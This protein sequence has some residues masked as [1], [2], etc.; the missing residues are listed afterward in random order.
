MYNRSFSIYWL[1]W[2]IKKWNNH[3]L[4][5]QNPAE[6]TNKKPS[7]DSVKIVLLEFASDVPSE[8]TEITTLSC[9]M[10]LTRMI[11]TSLSICLRIS[12]QLLK[13]KLSWCSTKCKISSLITTN[14]QKYSKNS[15]ESRGILRMGI[16][17]RWLSGNCKRTTFKSMTCIRA[18]IKKC[19][20]TSLWRTRSR[21]WS[22]KQT[23]LTSLTRWET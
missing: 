15:E 8:F 20:R 13:T 9:S 12:W 11:W 18:C 14:C 22:K 16:T 2:I 19:R 6:T 7:K 17:R 23:C 3:Q 5:S 21:L 10:K 1:N 4:P